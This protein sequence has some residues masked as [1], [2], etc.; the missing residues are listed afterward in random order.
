MMFFVVVT[1]DYVTPAEF[2]Q[3][4]SEQVNNLNEIIQLSLVLT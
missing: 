4:P 1:I 3:K 2:T